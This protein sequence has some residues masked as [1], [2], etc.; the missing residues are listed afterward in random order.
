MWSKIIK[1]KK[2]IKNLYTKLL[3]IYP[4]IPDSN[5]TSSEYDYFY[6]IFL[7]EVEQDELLI[8]KENKNYLTHLNNYKR[9][10]GD[11]YK[12]L[13]DKKSCLLM[14]DGYIEVGLIMYFSNNFSQVFHFEFG[15]FKHNFNI[16]DFV[17]K[18]IEHFHTEV[19]MNGIRF[20]NLSNVFGKHRL[21]FVRGVGL[22]THMAKIYIR[23]V[24][25]FENGLIYIINLLKVEESDYTNTIFV[26]SDFKLD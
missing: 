24:P 8:L 9:D 7:N 26:D 12:S 21:V 11:L 16:N 10:K 6:K 2:D 13:F 17:P 25:N 1:L 18:S 23:P 14:V 22:L 20:S 15:K 4:S 19:V 5:Q 3:E